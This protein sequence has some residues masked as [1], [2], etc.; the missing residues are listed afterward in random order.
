[1]II[2]LQVTLDSV[3]PTLI[4]TGEKGGTRI[5]LGSNSGN[6]NGMYLG[7]SSSLSATTGY[8]VSVPGIESIGSA[9]FIDLPHGNSL[10]AIAAAGNSFLLFVMLIPLSC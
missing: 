1:M 5:R 6:Q 8:F 7:G 10:Y 4:A 2:S 3:T 9:Q